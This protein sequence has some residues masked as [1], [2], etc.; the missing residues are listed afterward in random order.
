MSSSQPPSKRERQ[1]QRREVQL[2][3]Q[4]IA[5]AK[6]RRNRL[7]AFGLLGVIFAGLIGAAVYNNRQN[8]A[9]FAAEKEAIAARLDGLGCT[10]DEETADAGAGHIEAAALAQNP[11]DALYP[12]RPATSGQHHAS[13]MI[14]GVYDQVIDER[15]LVHNLEHGYIVAYYDEGAAEEDVTALKELAQE[16]IEGK[17][18]K[19]IVAQWDGDLGGE[20]NFAYAAWNARQMCAEYDEDVFGLF[21]SSHHSG[22]GVAPEKEVP[23]HTAPDSGIDP[24]TDPFL[25]PPLGEAQPAPGTSEGTPSGDGASEAA[26]TEASS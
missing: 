9:Q 25:L 3:Q 10:P 2:E 7:L 12:D 24:G 11:P 23:P 18:P 13:W 16:G 15:A 20:A 17:Y 4:R 6:S 8:A 5:E 1:K 26:P 22:E 14:T 21:T 19:T